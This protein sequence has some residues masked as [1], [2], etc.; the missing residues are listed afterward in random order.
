[1]WVVVLSARKLYLRAIFFL[2]NRFPDLPHLPLCFIGCGRSPDPQ[3]KSDNRPSD[4]LN[5]SWQGVSRGNR[6]H[7]ALHAVWGGGSLGS[8]SRV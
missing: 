7:D 4:S 5:S 6:Y 1:M 8:L 3:L 2:A